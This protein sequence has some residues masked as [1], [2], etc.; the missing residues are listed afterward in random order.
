M[1]IIGLFRGELLYFESEVF[2]PAEWDPV[3]GVG[4]RVKDPPK[5]EREP[6]RL[7][8]ERCTKGVN[9]IGASQP[10][11]NENHALVQAGFGVFPCDESGPSAIVGPLAAEFTCRLNLQGYA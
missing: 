8:F 1:G 5:D 9:L 10:V 11:A 3:A 6:H 4:A 7:L 2:E